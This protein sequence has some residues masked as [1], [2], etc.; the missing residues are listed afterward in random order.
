MV[1]SVHQQL[2]LSAVAPHHQRD[3]ISGSGLGREVRRLRRHR[4]GRARHHRLLPGRVRRL[5]GE[6]VRPRPEGEALDAPAGPDGAHRPVEGTGLHRASACPPL[7][8]PN[9]ENSGGMRI[10]KRPSVDVGRRHL[11]PSTWK[12][13]P[14]PTGTLQG[15][16]QLVSEPRWHRRVR[17]ISVAPLLA[18][19]RGEDALRGGD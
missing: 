14:L 5:R 7:I 9:R 11:A 12:E 19:K 13:E 18:R 17:V 6:G 10:L 2:A 3:T 1:A 4:A 15:S 16:P 8:R